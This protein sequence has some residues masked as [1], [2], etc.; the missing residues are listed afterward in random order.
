MNDDRA[1]T[2]AITALLE[3]LRKALAG[4][5]DLKSDRNA[6]RRRATVEWSKGP[7][8]DSGG[9]A[10]DEKVDSPWVETESAPGAQIFQV[11]PGVVQIFN[12]LIEQLL[13]AQI[14]EWANFDRAI[15][16]WKKGVTES[17]DKLYAAIASPGGCTQDER[18]GMLRAIAL[19]SIR[20]ESPPMK[21][22]EVR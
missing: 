4:N 14:A 13:R 17:I 5:E 1:V 9:E 12:G 10:V 21:D 2:T 8:V 22:G 15:L 19:L 7:Y 18:P 11:G 6:W 16:C 20:L 3:R